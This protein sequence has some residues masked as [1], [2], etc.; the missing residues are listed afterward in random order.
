MIQPATSAFFR[1]DG[2]LAGWHQLAA[3][4][5]LM[6][7]YLNCDWFPGFVVLIVILAVK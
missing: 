5:C 1:C 7:K 3:D 4:V 2:T 6:C